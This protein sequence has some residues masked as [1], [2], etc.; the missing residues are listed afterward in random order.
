MI[1]NAVCAVDGGQ[2]EAALALGYDEALA[3]S[4][5]ILPQSRGLY[6]Q[7]LHSQFI[8]LM[9]ETSVAGYITVLDLT[10]AGDLIRSRTMEAFFPLIAI[11]VIY[12]V[13]TLLLTKAVGLIDLQIE[14]QHD[15]RKIRGV[16]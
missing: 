6:Q 3:F 11:A 12:F 1:W 7:L 8:L 2:R 13:L 14:R 4:Q 16:D 5:V 9:K 10:R 15:S